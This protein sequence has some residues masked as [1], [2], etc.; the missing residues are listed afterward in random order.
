MT[1]AKHGFGHIIAQAGLDVLLGTSARVKSSSLLIGEETKRFDAAQRLVM[2]FEELGPTFIKFG[3]VLA[4]RADI[5]PP[6]YLKAFSRLQD[7]VEPLDVDTITAVIEKSLGKSLSEVFSSFDPVPLAS[8]SIGQTHTAVLH[9]GEKVVVKVKRPGTDE[10]IEED[11][12]LLSYLAKLAEKHIPELKPASPVLIVEEFDRCLKQEID[13]VTEAAYTEKFSTQIINHDKIRC[14]QIYWDY[15]S[16]DV[17]VEEYF[18]GISVSKLSEHSTA[19]R[20]EIAQNLARCFLRQYFIDGFFHSDPHP[21]NIMLMPDNKIGIIDFGQTGQ[22]SK[23]M[24]KQFVVMLLA[25]SRGDIDVIIDICTSIGI[26]SE[27][28]NLRE[29]KNEFSSYIIR[30][31][32]LPMERIDMSLAINEGIAIA[33]RCGLIL[34]RDFILLTKSFI[35]LQGVLRSIAPNF[36]FNEALKP[37]LKKVMKESLDIKENLWGS[38]FYLFRVI[39]MLKRA[40]EDIRDIMSKLRAGKTRIIFHHEGLEEISDQVERASNRLTLGLL[41]SAILLGS[42]IILASGPKLIQ[43]IELPF[44]EGI[45]LSAI[46]A[47]GGYL[48]ALALGFWLAWGI[49]SGKRL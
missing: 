31:Y 28:T 16:H 27:N 23:D 30:F 45:P 43:K 46:I 10:R 42:S 2:G 12:S 37:F 19:Q 6:S 18:E 48:I 34:P 21:G 44:L 25:L 33:R 24:R 17:M 47:S 3:Q 36:L 1:L 49:L 13:F 5:L 22:I 8:G 29:F 35:T 4:T 38:G 40:P 32:G 26:M 39:S 14:P 15:V 41:I 20:T 9:S 7:H 11:L